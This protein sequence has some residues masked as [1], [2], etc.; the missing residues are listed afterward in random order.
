[1]PSQP[2]LRYLLENK[3]WNEAANLKYTGTFRGKFKWQEAIFHLPG[4]GS[5]YKIDR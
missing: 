3:I 1:M 2:F 5:V 4:F